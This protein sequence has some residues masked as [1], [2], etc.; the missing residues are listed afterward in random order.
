MKSLLAILVGLNMAY[1]QNNASLEEHIEIRED[2]KMIEFL[3]QDGSHHGGQFR[4]DD[5][6]NGGDGYLNEEGKIILRDFDSGNFYE[7]YDRFEIVEKEESFRILLKDI[8][9]AS[10]T[11]GAAIWNAMEH[12]EFI[13]IE[14]TLPLLPTSQTTVGEKPAE[15]QIAIKNGE[16]I[17]ISMKRFERTVD[18]EFLLLH[19]VLHEVVDREEW[20][21]MKHT[22]VRALVNYIYQNRNNLKEDELWKKLDDYSATIRLDSDK[23]NEPLDKNISA[24]YKGLLIQGEAERMCDLFSMGASRYISISQEALGAAY[25]INPSLKNCEQFGITPYNSDS[26]F[27]FHTYKYDKSDYTKYLK[28]YPVFSEFITKSNNPFYNFRTP[29]LKPVGAYLKSERKE[30]S[31]NDCKTNTRIAKFNEMKKKYDQ[32]KT[33]ENDYK[34]FLTNYNPVKKPTIVF[35]NFLKDVVVG[36]SFDYNLNAMIRFSETFNENRRECKK[37]YST[38]RFD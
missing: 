30:V 18:R 7:E 14:D 9:M 5:K 31:F 29:Y 24:Y 36:K 37:R 8:F 11:V 20:I 13:F 35:F 25:I 4:F 21:A 1:A 17:I 22:K 26:E 27:K 15:V 23:L 12:L 28:N 34:R 19:E 3:K 16:K 2:E 32:L 10:P 33:V 6:D 38:L